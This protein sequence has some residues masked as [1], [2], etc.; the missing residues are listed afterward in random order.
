MMERDFIILVGIV[1]RTKKD[2]T[3]ALALG[4]TKQRPENYNQAQFKAGYIW[5]H[6][7]GV[8]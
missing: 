2:N 7:L 1:T 6:C 8:Y 3:K 5:Q 4:S